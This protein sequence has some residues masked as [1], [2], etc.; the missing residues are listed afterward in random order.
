MAVTLRVRRQSPT[1]AP[2]PT[3]QVGY[4]VGYLCTNQPHYGFP[5]FFRYMPGFFEIDWIWVRIGFSCSIVTN[6]GMLS[7]AVANVVSCPNLS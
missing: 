1:P 2:G 3:V 6:L 7:Q 4:R 5:L